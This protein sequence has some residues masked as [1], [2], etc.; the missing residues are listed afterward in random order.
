MSYFGP[1]SEH[2]TDTRRPFTALGF[3]PT[4][5]YI[6][7]TSSSRSWLFVPRARSRA[8]LSSMNF[9]RLRTLVSQNCMS[10]YLHGVYC[11]SK[12]SMC[13]PHA[14]HS[15]RSAVSVTS[16]AVAYLD[17]VFRPCRCLALAVVNPGTC[18]P[19]PSFLP[20]FSTSTPIHHHV[21]IHAP[22]IYL[23]PSHFP[24]HPR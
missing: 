2:R 8:V 18:P 7:S 3:G 11:C 5:R 10:A 4:A 20:A 24:P 22:C 6:L 16:P 9:R 14:V 23:F 13:R 21:H 15:P 12:S 19:P 1:V 17:P